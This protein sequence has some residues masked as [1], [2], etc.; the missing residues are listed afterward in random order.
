MFSPCLMD[1]QSLCFLLA[2]PG[3][4]VFLVDLDAG[5]LTGKRQL[6]HDLR[7]LAGL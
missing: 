7:M 5:L 3:G 6:R 4:I 2:E 1:P